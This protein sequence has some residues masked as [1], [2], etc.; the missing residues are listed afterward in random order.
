MTN[1]REQI[2]AERRRRVAALGHGEGAALPA[3]RTAPLVPF[4]AEPGMICE[5]KRASPSKGKI[6][7]DLDV[8]A[9]T[10]RYV[11]SGAANISVLTEPGGF[12]GSLDD[13]RAVKEAFPA[14]A[15]LRKDFLF[16]PEDIDVAWRAGADAV[17]LIAAMLP[18]DR[19]ADLYR[20]A[21][22]RGMEV[23]VELHDAADV[24]KARA[25][26][27]GLVGV[28][29]RDLATFRLDPLLPLRVKA[30]VDW[31]ARV[32]YESGI[33]H[34]EQ[35][36]FAAAS[37]FAGILVGEA[38]V[39]DP[40]LPRRLL[41]A[42]RAAKPD[43][44]WNRLAARMNE[45]AGRPLVKIC[46]LTREG[47]ARLAR[48]LGADLLGFVFWDKSPR[49]ADPALLAKIAHLDTPKVAVVVGAKESP[50]LDAGIKTLLA[51]GL[52]DAVQFHGD[53]RPEDCAALWP[54]YYKAV[55]PNGRPEAENPGDFR[56]PRV[57]LDAHAATPGGSGT[58]VADEIAAA[59]RAPLWLAGGLGPGNV[60][61]AV[62]DHSPE[63]VD[64]AG[65]VE[66]MPGVKN[67]DKLAAFMA[68][69]RGLR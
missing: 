53:E 49:R 25:F 34:P 36:A 26:R 12:S 65:G 6:A 10:G 16:D 19:L 62:A 33:R 37:G 3:A 42:M 51:D 43:R 58:R 15:A 14:T 31:P 7:A 45:L 1:I 59:W 56:C 54:A 44:F 38:V 61:A 29:S 2:V 48:D 32:V 17:L 67:R 8:V 60:R 64:V 28:N 47:D 69:C 11:A 52:L 21:K 46:G 4:M 27:P 20:L 23:L 55:R 5:I 41:D 66:E 39:R 18:A 30:L 9:Q 50:A 68:A 35:A 24:A 22:Q 57:L 40:A 63:L 13:L